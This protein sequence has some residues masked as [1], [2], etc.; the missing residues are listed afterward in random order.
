MLYQPKNSGRKGRKPQIVA[1]TDLLDQARHIERGG[2]AVGRSDT[3]WGISGRHGDVGV[4]RD[5][6]TILGH[7]NVAYSL[8]ITSI[9]MGER[10]VQFKAADYRVLDTMP[11]RIT[12]VA[13]VPEERPLY[14]RMSRALHVPDGKTLGI[15]ISKGYEKALCGALAA[16]LI[17]AAVRAGNDIASTMDEAA[18][19]VK[20]A[21]ETGVITRDVLFLKGKPTKFAPS[22][23]FRTF[24][25]PDGRSS[26]HEIFRQG[27]IEG[28]TIQTAIDQKW[29]PRE[30]G[31]A[32]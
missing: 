30:L 18:D 28:S 32:T 4:I 11:D 2:L 31:D 23:V 22:T 10:F 26:T 16:P 19:M 21:M 9:E 25:R 15:R 1:V 17:T 12:L 6:D 3:C 14:R 29:T 7:S 5:L 24:R 20:A 13:E 27:D 8:N